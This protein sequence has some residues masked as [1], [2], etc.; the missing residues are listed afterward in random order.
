MWGSG[1]LATH[2][3]GGSGLYSGLTNLDAG[4]RLRAGPPSTPLG[5]RSGGRVKGFKSG[6]FALPVRCGLD[7]RVFS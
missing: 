4:G 7:L 1:A 5:R 3:D 2:A 6:R